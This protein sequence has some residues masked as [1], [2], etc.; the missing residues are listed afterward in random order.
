MF[1]D[2]FIIVMFHFMKT[3]HVKLPDKTV[4]FLMPKISR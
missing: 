1:E 4:N 3:I 2:T